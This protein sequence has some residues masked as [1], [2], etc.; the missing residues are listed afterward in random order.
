MSATFLR[1][2]GSIREADSGRLARR[3][4]L[5]SFF[6]ECHVRKLLDRL[7]SPHARAGRTHGGFGFAPPPRISRAHATYAALGIAALT[8]LAAGSAAFNSAVDDTPAD[9]AAASLAQSEQ[10][11]GAPPEPAPAPTPAAMAAA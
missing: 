4:P 10:Q 6:Q 1:N 3:A 2:C 7:T 9:I 5:L 11:A 8:L